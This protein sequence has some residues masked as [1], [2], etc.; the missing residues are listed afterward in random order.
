MV[1]AVDD[2]WVDP[3]ALAKTLGMGEH[4]FRAERAGAPE[5][6]WNQLIEQARQERME[7]IGEAELEEGGD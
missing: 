3:E 2:P 4:S 5:V 1:G 6:N 7:R